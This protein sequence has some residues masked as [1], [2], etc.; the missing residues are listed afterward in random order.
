MD[1]MGK[2]KGTDFLHFYV[3]GSI[4]REGRW[5][6]LYDAQA[7]LVR[8]QA[9]APSSPDVVFVP[10]ESPQ[11]ALLFAP[12]TALGY[13]TALL[14]GFAFGALL[15]AAC[16]ALL[17]ATRPRSTRTATSSPPRASRFRLPDGRS[18]WTDRV[19]L[20]RLRR[21]RAAG[22]SAPPHVSR[23]WRSGSWCSSHTGRSW[24]ADYSFWQASGAWLQDARPPRSRGGRDLC[25]RRFVRD[26]HVRAR[27]SRSPSRGRSAPAAAGRLVEGYVQAFV[28]SPALALVLY[29][30][31]VLATIAL[32]VR[33]WR[34]RRRSISGWRRW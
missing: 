19:A 28:A 21:A 11:L 29:A 7:Q 20:A 8:A 12:L 26:A 17:C 13:T 10:L 24:P 1:R 15:Y 30:A 23:V 22:A 14:S 4:V 34:A 25:R 9:I 3:I 6:E 32:T 33:I 16:C 2:V 27:A 5:S 31:A 18:A